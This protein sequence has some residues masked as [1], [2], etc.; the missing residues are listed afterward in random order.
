M[1]RLFAFALFSLVV[2]PCLTAGA[3]DKQPGGRLAIKSEVMGEERVILVRTPPGYETGDQRYP[4]LYMTDGAA[5]LGHTASTIEFLSRNGRMPE[6]IVVA[7]TNTDRTRDLTPTKAAMP[8]PGGKDAQFPTS[9]GADKFLKFI[10]TELIPQVEKTYRTQPYRIFAGHSFGGLLA[11]HAFATK[12]DLFNAYIAVSP[13]LQWDKEGTVNKTADF[14]KDRKD[15]K[16]ALYFT[17]GNEG[18]G[19]LS[20]FNKTKELLTKQQLNGFTWDSA[21]MDDE[22]HGTVVLRSHYMGLKKIFD[23][24]QPGPKIVV[25]GADAV[26]EHFKKLSAKFNY[27]I[28]PPEQMMNQ[29]GYQLLLGAKKSDEALAVFVSNVKRYPNSANVYDSLAEAY[30]KTGKLD[31]AK[32]NYERAAQLGAKNSDPNLQLYRTN[33]ERVSEALKKG[34]KASEKN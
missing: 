28:V 12:N 21:L 33:F 11:V 25:G 34:G 17:M 3:Q 24:W 13:S 18:G 1:K 16:S 8:G 9:G 32:T 29:L 19:M 2:A 31:L 30:E 20:A 4:V 14:L 22:D 26:E 10:E 5:Q 6:M 7:I 27:T 23:G 15:L